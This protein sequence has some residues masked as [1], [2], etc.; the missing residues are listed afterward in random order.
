MKLRHTIQAVIRSGDDSG[1][2]AECVDLPVVTQGAT[3]EE[4]LTNLREAVGLLLEGEDLATWNL[5]PHPSIVVMIELEPD[6]A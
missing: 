1:Y 6:Y 4:S 3:V 2:V 5:A